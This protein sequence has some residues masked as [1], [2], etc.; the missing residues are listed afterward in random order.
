MLYGRTKLSATGTQVF[1]WLRRTVPLL[2]LSD[3]SSDWDQVMD[4]FPQNPTSLFISLCF[5]PTL[6]SVELIFILSHPNTQLDKK[7]PI[8][9]LA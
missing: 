8:Y 7:H 9:F 5:A 4:P 3:Q 1:C 6:K 2:L